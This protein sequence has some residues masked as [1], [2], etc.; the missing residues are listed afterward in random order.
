MRTAHRRLAAFGATALATIP[1]LAACTS[2]PATDAATTDAAGS[3]LIADGIRVGDGPVTVVVF[4]DAACP[5]C[6]ILDAEVGDTLAAAVDAGEITLELHPMTYV[7]EKRGDTTDYST[8]SAALLFAAADAGE[9]DAVPAL[10]ALIQENQVDETGAPSDEELLTYAAEAGVT[11]DLSTALTGD[12]YIDL[13]RAANDYWLGREI[14]GTGEAL[15]YV[16]SVAVDGAFFEVRE[17]G[18]DLTRLEAAIADAG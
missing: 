12:E 16:P 5:H 13:A 7:S 15:Q 17:D 10:Y 8:R 11:A 14:P 4:G 6:M 3:P 2:A 1:L 9:T 18:T